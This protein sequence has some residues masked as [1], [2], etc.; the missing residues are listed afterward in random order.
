MSTETL[1]PTSRNAILALFITLAIIGTVVY[2]VNYLDQ[3]RVQ[4]LNA[5][6]T[7]LSTDTLSIETQ[8]SL[9]EE[10]PCEDIAEGTLLSQEVGTLGDKLAYTENRLGSD[11]AEV[12]QLKKQY[13]LLQIR[14]YLLTKRLRETCD[15]EPVVALYFY[16]N[17]GDCK[18]CERA[19]AALSYLRETYPRLRVYSFD[20]H[21]E[22]GAL[23][24][25]EQVEKVEPVFP[26]FIIE[27]KR[28]Y[29]FTT[30]EDFEK[31]FPKR[32]FAA[33]TTNSSVIKK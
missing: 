10:V 8:F 15:L 26:A 28:S 21:L 30:L 7:Q 22:L 2:A 9:L 24:T 18:D 32:L 6:Q 1:S 3:Q 11:N 31:Q 20:Y 23:Q 25:L 27:G 33:T 12:L 19:G 17:A 16:S 29:G 4:E 5:I 13:T 14:D